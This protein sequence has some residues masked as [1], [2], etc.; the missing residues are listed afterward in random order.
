[1]F[2]ANRAWRRRPRLKKL[3]LFLAL[4]A[5]VAA[6]VLRVRY[7]GGQPYVDL[8]TTPLLAEQA[9]DNT[10]QGAKIEWLT[11]RKAFVRFMLPK[12]K[13][14]RIVEEYEQSLTHEPG[15]KLGG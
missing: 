9:L 5:L 14:R 6:A 10:K 1:M 4:A 7:G 2:E 3:F 15:P 11:R 13:K 8:S 12:Y